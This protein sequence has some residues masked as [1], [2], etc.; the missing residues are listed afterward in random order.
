MTEAWLGLSTLLGLTDVFCGGKTMGESFPWEKQDEMCVLSLP[1]SASLSLFYPGAYFCDV[2]GDVRLGPNVTTYL[3]SLCV[4]A[5]PASSLRL[6][7]WDNLGQHLLVWAET[8]PGTMLANEVLPTSCWSLVP[9]TGMGRRPARVGCFP[10]L[11]SCAPG[12]RA[13]TFTDH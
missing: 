4:A 9:R 10:R 13:A 11:F 12:Y 5:A 1:L 8:V 2:C 7:W 3:C 6:M